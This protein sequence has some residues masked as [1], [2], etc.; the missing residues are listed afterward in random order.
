MG[1]AH[2]GFLPSADESDWR[3]RVARGRDRSL[4]AA[5]RARAKSSLFPGG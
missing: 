5:N 1:H 3:L 4:P 2:A